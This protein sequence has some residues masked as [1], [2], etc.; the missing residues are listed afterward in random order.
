MSPKD[1]APASAVTRRDALAA[2]AG[3]LGGVP[4]SLGELLERIG[5]PAGRPWLLEAAKKAA[6]WDSGEERAQVAH[7]APDA[8]QLPELLARR[9][10]RIVLSGDVVPEDPRTTLPRGRAG[11]R[12][13]D[14]AARVAVD[15][16][17][18]GTEE[19]GGAGMKWI[20]AEHRVQPEL[21]VAQTGLMQGAAG[22]G[23]ALLHLDGAMERRRPFMMLPDNPFA[24][25]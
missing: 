5:P 11:R 7:L 17:R 9:G 22:V 3:L 18:R 10:G 20:Q 6:V 1:E 23:L 8:A 14:M 12:H 13:L 25:I 21:L 24:A 4:A 15:T 16:L 2:A 19:S